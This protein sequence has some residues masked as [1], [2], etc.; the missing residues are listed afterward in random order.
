[1]FFRLFSSASIFISTMAVARASCTA[2]WALV[3][4]TPISLHS[5]PS[6]WFLNPGYRLRERASVSKVVKSNFRPISGN[7]RRKKD[8]SN[9]ALCATSTAP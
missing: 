4:E 1:M 3:S 8:M 2:R 5:V 9:S 7:A 6:L